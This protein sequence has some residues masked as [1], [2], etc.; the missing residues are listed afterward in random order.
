MA[1]KEKSE[2][3]LYIQN[4]EGMFWRVDYRDAIRMKKFGYRVISQEEGE[5]LF[6]KGPVAVRWLEN[7]TIITHYC[8]VQPSGTVNK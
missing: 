8:P 6:N 2:E 7:G 1:E 5:A 4:R 3:I